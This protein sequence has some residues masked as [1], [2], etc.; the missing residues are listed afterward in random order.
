MGLKQNPEVPPR[1]VVSDIKM[2][3]LPFEQ[4]VITAALLN[5]KLWPWERSWRWKFRWMTQLCVLTSAQTGE[6]L[7]LQ[8]CRLL[9]SRVS[10]LKKETLLSYLSCSPSADCDPRMSARASLWCD[11]PGERAL[12]HTLPDR[13]TVGATASVHPSVP[14]GHKYFTLTICQRWSRSKS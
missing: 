5:L 12:V 7:H 11:S 3:E 9:L 6:I 4:Q 13:C 8:R 2:L 10:S 14:A 1:F